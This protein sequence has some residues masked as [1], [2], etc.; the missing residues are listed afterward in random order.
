MAKSLTEKSL[1]GMAWVLADKFGSTLI[2]FVVNI[3]LARLLTE[4]DFGIIAMVFVFFEIST[5]L[6][7]SGLPI[8]LIREKD[9]SEEDKSTT[10]LFNLAAALLMYAV[11]FASAPL[12][13]SFFDQDI[14]EPIVRVMSVNLILASFSIIQR[15][16]LEREL[17]FKTQTKT[18][19]AAILISG[20]VGVVMAFAGFGVWSLVT[21]FVLMSFLD[22]LFLWII[23]DWRPRLIFSMPSFRRLF[24]FGSKILATSF[25]DRSFAHLSK[26]VIGRFFS[27]AALGSYHWAN[28]FS[29]MVVTSLFQT[30][31][32]VSYPLLSKLNT[33][34]DA[35]KK[36]YRQVLRISSFVMVPS[37]IG[38]AA[39]AEPL[40]IAT[41]GPKWTSAVPFLELLCIAGVA[42]HLNAINLNMLLVLGR[43]DLGL[44]LEIYKKI[45]IALAIA[46]GVQFGIIGLVIGEVISAYVALLINTAYSKRLLNYSL[47]E[48]LGDVKAT[49]II[50]VIMGGAVYGVDHL[51]DAPA[52]LR[53]GIG[54][55][56]GAGVYFGLHIVSRSSEMELLQNIVVPKLRKIFRKSPEL[57]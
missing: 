4:E 34:K 18:R 20:I 50:A 29:N 13:A 38:M 8:A 43:S 54:M 15:T 25:L 55:V 33:D 42:F 16:L 14:L 23:S 44:A 41:I 5:T 11:L 49:A 52:F 39:L 45:G 48:Q 53:V 7:Y 22:T 26:V 56:V 47:I 19:L 12:I 6:V 32:R 10:F 27:M 36:G 3:I 35:L 24:G 1:S 30:I 46:I 57:S 9:I 28:T 21:K 40:I 2:N 17:H 31:Q 37:M 51:I